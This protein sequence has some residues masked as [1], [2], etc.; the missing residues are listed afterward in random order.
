MHNISLYYLTLIPTGKIKL[1]ASCKRLEA[2]NEKCD[3]QLKVDL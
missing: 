2:T 3:D 1:V